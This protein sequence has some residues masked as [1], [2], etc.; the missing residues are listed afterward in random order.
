MVS[1]TTFKASG[2]PAYAS[3]GDLQEYSDV[4]QGAITSH[5]MQ[6]DFPTRCQYTKVGVVYPQA[7]QC[8]C[9]VVWG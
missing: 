8:L 1:A 6:S 4:Q 9:E 7:G 3:T 2:L 5:L